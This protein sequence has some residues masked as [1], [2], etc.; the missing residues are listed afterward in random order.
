M[1]VAILLSAAAW[2]ASVA[3]CSASLEISFD[4]TPDNVDAKVQIWGIEQNKAKIAAAREEHRAFCEALRSIGEGAFEPLFGK[5][6]KETSGFELKRAPLGYAV[7]LFESAGVGFSGYGYKGNLESRFYPVSDIGGVLMFPLGNGK[8]VSAVFIYLKIDD[9]FVPIRST[10]DYRA[11]SDWDS[12][13][14]KL[15]RAWIQ[16]EAKKKGIDLHGIRP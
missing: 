7:P 10:A 8:F 9:K 16:A 5:L 3:V 14:L 12:A 2:I 1:K 13:K 4:C 6:S 11:R 15:L